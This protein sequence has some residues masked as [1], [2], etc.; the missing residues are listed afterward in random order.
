MQ[1]A[2]SAAPMTLRASCGSLGEFVAAT[3]TLL[4][5][6]GNVVTHPGEAEYRR[7]R[8]ANAA[9]QSK[10]RRHAGG[11]AAMEAFG[12]VEEGAGDDAALVMSEQNA[13]HEG[14]RAMRRLLEQ[15]VPPTG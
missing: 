1:A 5:F 6:V 4:V 7:V 10:P 13:R 11:V 2:I 8:L 15:A 12:F 14:C 9:F 3:R